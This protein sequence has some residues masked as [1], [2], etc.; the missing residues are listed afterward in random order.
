ML[1]TQPNQG[2]TVEQE[3]GLLQMEYE[4]MATEIR[5]Y[6]EQYSPKFNI[7]GILVI[8]AI[9]FAW[10]NPQYA[11]VYPIIPYFLFVICGVTIA[12]AYILT[13][14]SERL[15]QIETRIAE[16]NAGKLILTWECVMS[17]K[18]IYPPWLK[19]PKK[20]GKVFSGPNPVF[21]SVVLTNI[22]LLPVITFCFI[23]SWNIIPSPWNILY[24]AFTAT[25][26]AVVIWYGTSFFRLG[27]I[28]SSL[29]YYDDK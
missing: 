4:R 8:S 3:L 5:M 2:L 18:L 19:I 28:M 10:Q 29:K 21:G 15:R 26:F 12:Q 24:L 20:D 22:A 11:M 1:N 25:L 6:V 13:C 14:L 17:M 9:T 16:L 27:D 7:F 23:K